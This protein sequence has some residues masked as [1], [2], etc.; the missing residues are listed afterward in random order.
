LTHAY[1]IT[2]AGGAVPQTLELTTPPVGQDYVATVT[3]QGEPNEKETNP[4]LCK[5]L[6]NATVEQEIT[7]TQ[8]V[9][10]IDTPITLQGAG[11]L[12]VGK[13]KVECTGKG[14]IKNL[15]LT[16]ITAASVE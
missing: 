13:I 7:E 16:A 9:K 3:G 4:M 10:G 12:S 14:S 5:L 6:F 15:R 2:A 1:T 11:L 8:V